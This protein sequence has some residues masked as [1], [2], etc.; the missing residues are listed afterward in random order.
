MAKLRYKWLMLHED[1]KTFI[2]DMLLAV[3]GS[4]LLVVLASWAGWL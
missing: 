3:I 4:A 2:V 1:T